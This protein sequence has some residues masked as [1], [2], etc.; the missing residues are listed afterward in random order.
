MNAFSIWLTFPC[1][2][3]ST[4]QTVLNCGEYVCA[5]YYYACLLPLWILRLLFRVDFFYD[6]S[7]VTQAHPLFSFLVKMKWCGLRAKEMKNGPFCM[8]IGWSECF[9]LLMWVYTVMW[10][11]MVD[12]IQ[13]E[14]RWVHLWPFFSL[15]NAQEEDRLVKWVYICGGGG[16][17]SVR[18]ALMCVCVFHFDLWLF[19]FTSHHT[20]KPKK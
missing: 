16:R 5:H 14:R 8:E 15:L 19:R 4:C 17:C 13:K 7:F 3:K 6:A 2:I 10:G 9:N 12:R 20:N 11:W 1:P 18:G